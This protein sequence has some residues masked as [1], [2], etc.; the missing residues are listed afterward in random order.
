MPGQTRCHIGFPRCAGL[1]LAFQQAQVRLDVGVALT[2]ATTT[3]KGDTR[4]HLGL[5]VNF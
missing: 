2:D 5:I 3:A 1:R 4:V